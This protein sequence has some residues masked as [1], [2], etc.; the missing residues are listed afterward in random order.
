MHPC[1]VS[2]NT[3]ITGMW[4]Y[5]SNPQVLSVN[6]RFIFWKSI[7]QDIIPGFSFHHEETNT[8]NLPVHVPFL[9]VAQ[10]YWISV[11]QNAHTVAVTAI[12]SC[13]NGGKNVCLFVCLVFFGG[14]G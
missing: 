4:L 11:D 5:L 10:S 12:V 8:C 3:G 14:G 7:R 1:Q 13:D 2:I 9:L 6:K